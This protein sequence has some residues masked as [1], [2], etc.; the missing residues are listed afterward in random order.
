MILPFSWLT[1]IAGSFAAAIA[2][3]AGRT[4]GTLLRAGGLF[5]TGSVPGSL[6]YLDGVVL[7]AGAFWAILTIL[8]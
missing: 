8:T 4:V 2:L 5:V 6:A 1:A 3:V 7:A